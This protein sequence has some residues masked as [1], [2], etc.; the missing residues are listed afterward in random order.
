MV[1]TAFLSITFSFQHIRNYQWTPDII[2]YDASRVVKSTSYYVQQ[3]FSFNR[4]THV[5]KTSPA[6]SPDSAPLFW[7]ASYNNETNTVFLKVSN[8]G[9]AD[10]VAKIFLD[11]P[12]T[13]FGT[14][15]SISSPALS[16]I[17][18]VFNVFNTIEKPEQ[19]IPVAFS[20]AIPLPDRFNYTF[21]ATSVTVITLHTSNLESF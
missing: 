10:L 3:M 16:P 19:I 5:L 20:F 6:S 2:T 1:M 18:G 4:G 12:I 7:V 17:S 21:P 15:T 14:A 8:T 11:F 13:G 9:T